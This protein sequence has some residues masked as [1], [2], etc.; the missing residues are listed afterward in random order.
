MHVTLWQ[1]V[2][3]QLRLWE[4]ETQRVGGQPA[5]LYQSFELPEYF[6]QC[7]EFAKQQGTWVFDDDRDTLIAQQDGHEAMK[8]F[9]K[10]IKQG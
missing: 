1:V 9:I 6:Y 2:S 5:V 10:G 3:D 7:V 4:R 8:A